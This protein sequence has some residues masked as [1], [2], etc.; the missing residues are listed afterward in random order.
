MKPTLSYLYV[1][2]EYPDYTGEEVIVMEMAEVAGI[3]YDLLRNRM[4][5][6]KLRGH[7]LVIN[8]SDLLPK[9]RN[10]G[11]KTRSELEEEAI[12]ALNDKFLRRPLV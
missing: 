1:G 5:I 10:V 9:K 11:R 6:K 12:A 3:T 8:D 7:E 2:T 4:G